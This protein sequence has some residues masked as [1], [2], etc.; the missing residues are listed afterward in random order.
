M[1]APKAQF[2][3]YLSLAYISLGLWTVEPIEK[4]WSK[5]PKS[6]H[7][8]CPINQLNPQRAGRFNLIETIQEK[9]KKK[10]LYHSFIKY[11]L[12]AEH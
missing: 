11:L 4:G 6:L 5:F 9:K 3:C 12:R 1:T 8:L 10:E 2:H 7:M